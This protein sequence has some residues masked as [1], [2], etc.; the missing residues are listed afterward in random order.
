MPKRFRDDLPQALPPP[1][2]DPS[3]PIL[4]SPSPS[5]SPD[6]SPPPS[7]SS[8]P[9]ICRTLQTPRNI[10]GL[11]RQ[12]Q[13]E[14]WPSH[15]PEEHVSLRDL[16]YGMP[17]PASGSGLSLQSRGLRDPFFPYPNE[18]SFR[19]GEWYW[20]CNGEKSRT[21]FSDLL[22]I[23]GSE[24]FRPEDVRHTAWDKINSKLASSNEGEDDWAETEWMDED[25]GWE[26]KPIRISV[27]FHRRTAKPGCKDYL[28]GDLYHRPLVSVIRE[29]LDDPEYTQQF[30]YDPFELF[31]RPA[32]TQSDIRV[33]GELYTS[34]A[35]LE[36]H[37]DLQSSPR[38]PGC[39]LP[40]VVVALMFWSDATHLTA[41]GT[42]KLW[43]CYLFFGNESKNR[44]NKPSN[45][46]CNHVAYFQSVQSPSLVTSPPSLKVVFY[47][48]RMHSRT[49]RLIIWGVRRRPMNS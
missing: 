34:P 44:R 12:Y 27:P 1:A 32:G 11:W 2:L 3:T 35:F 28:V 42:A 45:N 13:Q 36:A 41:F 5:S 48:F 33:H 22:N 38:E 26:R 29:K 25:A 19:L 8:S 47:S 15:D 17:I 7:R 20:N 21:S 16:T 31:W 23:V 14:E 43:P 6:S 40:R 4:S 49:L 37:R 46:L 10:F 9:G 39:N 18:T 30:H 24:E